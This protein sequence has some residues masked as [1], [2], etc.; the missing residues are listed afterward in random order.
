MIFNLWNRCLCVQILTISS[1]ITI[2]IIIAII[3]VLY[4]YCAGTNL[5]LWWRT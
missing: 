4:R 5:I 3:E 2:I 1:T